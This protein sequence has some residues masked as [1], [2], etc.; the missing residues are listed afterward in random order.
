MI[1]K[2]ILYYDINNI[3][4]KLYY[5]MQAKEL[6]LML[7][8]GDIDLNDSELEPMMR[9]ETKSLEFF[10]GDCEV[11][12]I[13]TKVIELYT[14]KKH[15]EVTLEDDLISESPEI[16]EAYMKVCSELL[17]IQGFEDMWDARSFIIAYDNEDHSEERA[18]LFVRIGI[19]KDIKSMFSDKRVYTLDN[20]LVMPVDRAMPFY[21]IYWYNDDGKIKYTSDPSKGKHVG[22]G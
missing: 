19:P 8:A 14:V 21:G 4:D 1:E 13:P 18:P 22:D 16:K 12:I 2:G 11:L 15:L 5:P 9:I 3:K 10:H 20:G 17:R 6:E 7:H